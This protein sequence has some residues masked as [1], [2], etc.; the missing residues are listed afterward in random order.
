MLFRSSTGLSNDFR[1]LV[2][3]RTD[4]VEIVGESITL[5]SRGR[6]FVGLC[7]FH[8][9]HSPSMT[10]SPER[11]S[12]KCWVCNE[13]GDCF[14]WVMKYDSLD[15]RDALEM[16]AKRANLELPKEF[17]GQAGSAKSQIGRAHV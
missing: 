5:I 13:G 3:S 10:I 7:P 14:S 8:D 11:Q 15:F 12:Y 16:L 6:D 4:L 9:D 2:R 17:R 1:E